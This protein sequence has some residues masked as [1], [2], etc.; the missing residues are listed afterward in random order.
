MGEEGLDLLATHVLWVP[1]V[2]E[3][4]VA[5]GPTDVGFFGADRIVLEPDGVTKLVE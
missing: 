2:A 5:P 3:Q 1:P 4:D